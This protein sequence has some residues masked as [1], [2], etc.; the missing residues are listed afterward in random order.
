M[1]PAT[2]STFCGN[3]S[4]LLTS[5]C[6]SIKNILFFDVFLFCFFTINDK[7]CG[8]LCIFLGGVNDLLVLFATGS[9]RSLAENCAVC[10]T[11]FSIAAHKANLL[12]RW[13]KFFS[14]S[15][16]TDRRFV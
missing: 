10:G 16:E 12:N 2:S 15:I 9:G 14:S 5:G 11:F 6:H 13:L 1:T 8:L 7:K 4:E 3:F